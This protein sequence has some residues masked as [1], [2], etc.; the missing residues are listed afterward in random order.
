MA[1]ASNLAGGAEDLHAEIARADAEFFA[2]FNT[3]DVETMGKMLAS[4]LEFY[5]DTAGLGGYAETMESTRNNC[6]DELGL[7]R[8]LVE[9]SL[10]VYP[11]KD[12]GAIQKGKH[13]FCHMQN[14]KNDCGTFEFVHVWKRT[15]DGWRITRVL[16]YGH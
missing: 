10:E 8:T 3:C 15:D 5:H 13:R 6:K 1:I 7:T 2:A 14:G 11:I 12:Y 4:D 9:A 16:S